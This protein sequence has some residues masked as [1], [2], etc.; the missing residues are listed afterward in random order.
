M[1]EGWREYHS[2]WEERHWLARA[3]EHWEFNLKFHKKLCEYLSPGD[4]LLD[5]GSGKGYSALYFAAQGHPVTGIDTDERSVA[6]ANEWAARL[7][8]PAEFVVADLFDFRAAAKYRIAYSMGLIE[9]LE[10]AAA[11]RFLALQGGISELVVSLAPTR[12]SER[13]VE[14]CPVPWIPQSLSSLKR[15]YEAAGLEVVGSF[16]AG[17]VCS[18]WDS[19]IK[20]A[21]P[22]AAFHFLQNRFAYAMGVAMVGRRKA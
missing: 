12:H 2:R 15:T 8:L 13:T 16:G 7:S 10:P 19:R 14:P 6:E 9:H 18:R 3:I 5:V 21:L 22:H 20:S 4:A 11:T 17:D 1:T